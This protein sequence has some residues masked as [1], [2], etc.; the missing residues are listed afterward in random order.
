[1]KKR[2]TKVSKLVLYLL[3]IIFI[4]IFV[5]DQNG[6]NVY[7]NYKRTM[8]TEEGI[9]RF[10]E[11]VALGNSIDVENYLAEEKDYSNNISKTSVMLSNNISSCLRRGIVKMFELITKNIE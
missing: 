9:K 11:D 2:A 10:E 4:I 7:K 3:V 6:F 1:M 8:M 5:S